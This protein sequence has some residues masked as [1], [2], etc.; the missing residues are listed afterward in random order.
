MKHKVTCPFC[1]TEW[2]YG[3]AKSK[4]QAVGTGN[5]KMPEQRGRDGHYNVAD[6]PPEVEDRTEPLASLWLKGDAGVFA[7]ETVACVYGAVS[8][9]DRV[10]KRCDC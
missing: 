2:E 8:L 1:R 3:D 6:Q 10:W 5:V 7:W 4:K 9:R